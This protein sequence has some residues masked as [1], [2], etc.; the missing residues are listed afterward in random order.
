MILGF[1]IGM[2][3]GTSLGIIVL[4][5]LISSSRADAERNGFQRRSMHVCSPKCTP[6]ANLHRGE[7]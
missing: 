2:V 3:L 1:V 7:W 4:G 5:L 6:L